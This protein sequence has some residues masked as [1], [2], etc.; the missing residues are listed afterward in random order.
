MQVKS[1]PPQQ[2]TV[3]DIVVL[4]QALY[5]WA[6]LPPN[7]SYSLLYFC[8]IIITNVLG[9]RLSH[10]DLINIY[11]DHIQVIKTNFIWKTD[12]TWDVF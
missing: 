4:G 1:S 11:S 9:R 3:A 2:D 10:T 12:L 6:T 7:V 8:L 5:H